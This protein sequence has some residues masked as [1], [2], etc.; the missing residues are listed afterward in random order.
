MAICTAEDEDARPAH[1][2]RCGD[3][4]A[5]S[6]DPTGANIPRNGCYEGWKHVTEFQLSVHEVVPAPSIRSRSSAVSARTATT[7]G[8]TL[9]CSLSDCDCKRL[10]GLAQREMQDFDS[11]D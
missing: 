6:I 10:S 7:S 9:P 4:Y 8:A 2:F 5:A 1:L 11:F 3:L